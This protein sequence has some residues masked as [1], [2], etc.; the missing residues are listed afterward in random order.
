MPVLHATDD[1]LRTF[2]F[3]NPMVIVKYVK[4]DCEH[5]KR[6]APHFEK[7]SNDPKYD[8]IRFLIADS[9]QNPV[10]FRE[11]GE[12]DMPFVSMYKEG[13]LIECASVKTE[14]EVRALLDKLLTFERHHPL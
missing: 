2:I 3:N 9:I 4:K 14:T 6:I 12:R 13:L 10:A 7:F 5:C 11:V 1:D 8:R